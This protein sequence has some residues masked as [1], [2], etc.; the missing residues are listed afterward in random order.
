MVEFNF[1]MKMFMLSIKIIL[2]RKRN[3][4]IKYEWKKGNLDKTNVVD[5]M[6]MKNESRNKLQ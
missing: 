1:Q 6:K 5:M 2:K 3:N 4:G